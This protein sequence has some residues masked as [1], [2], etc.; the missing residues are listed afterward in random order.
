LLAT[1]VLLTTGSSMGCGLSDAVDGLAGTAVIPLPAWP[2]PTYPKFASGA[3]I[4]LSVCRPATGNA[5][6]DAAVGR[7][8]AT[9]ARHALDSEWLG[10]NLPGP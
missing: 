4:A 10:P 9:S 3:A 2:E 5:V 6:I 8:T 7:P 1:N